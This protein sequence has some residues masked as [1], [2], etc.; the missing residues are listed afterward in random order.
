MTTAP[1]RLLITGATGKQGGALI[2]SLL[3]QPPRTPTQIVALTRDP[4]SSS[5]KRLLASATSVAPSTLSLTLL[6]GD[7]DD[8]TKIFTSAASQFNNPHPFHGVFSVQ[9]PLNPTREEAQGKALIDAAARFGVR[10]FVYTSADRGG[11]QRS[12][13]DPSPVRHFASKFRIEEHLKRVATAEASGM[14]WT[15]IRPV[16]FME[17]LS[18]DFLGR[19]FVAMWRLN[20]LDDRPLQLVSASDVGVAAADALRSPQ[21]WAGRS[22]SLAGEEI[23]PAQADEVF[24]RLVGKPLPSTYAFVG[25]GLRWGLREQLGDMFDWFRDVGFGADVQGC[26]REWPKMMGWEMWLRE[27][28]AWKGRVEAREREN[29]AEARD[30]A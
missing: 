13:A 5:A 11:Q 14:A 12:D 24:R 10:H 17:N 9:V 8:S 21:K 29:G 4:A 30:G 27:K 18:D 22:V 3:R 26:R 19:A 2:A 1:Q 20:G 25:R 28:S 7:L 16:A 15:I 23:S 6:Q